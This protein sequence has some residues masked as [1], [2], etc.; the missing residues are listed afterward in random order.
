MADP[1]CRVLWTTLS[2]L[3]NEVKFWL[4]LNPVDPMSELCGTMF[5][6]GLRGNEACSRVLTL[7]AAGTDYRKWL[8]LEDLG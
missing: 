3:P 4:G 1:S 6:D 7:C 2:S 8:D 5:G